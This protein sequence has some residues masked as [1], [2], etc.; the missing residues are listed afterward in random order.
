ME[1]CK[2]TNKECPTPKTECLK[3]ISKKKSQAKP[4][5]YKPKSNTINKEE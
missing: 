1:K 3:C 5:V 4:A 2:F